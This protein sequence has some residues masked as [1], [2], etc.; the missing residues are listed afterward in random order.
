M[1]MQ[2]NG[3]RQAIQPLKKARSFIPFQI[4]EATKPS[5]FEEPSALLRFE[6]VTA[7]CTQAHDSVRR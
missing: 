7:E 1:S 3:E 5:G 2:C 6:E 4:S